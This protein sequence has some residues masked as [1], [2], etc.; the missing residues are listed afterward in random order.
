MSYRVR[1]RYR[2]DTGEVEIFRVE[3]TG[4]EARSADH[5]RRHE[6]ATLDVAR[7]IERNPLIEEEPAQSAVTDSAAR[8]RDGVEQAE[9][10]A[11]RR[12]DRL[13]G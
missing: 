10:E 6:R 3:D 2:S 12:D 13:H 5:D 4:G 9:A 11:K 8:T 1:F 7:V